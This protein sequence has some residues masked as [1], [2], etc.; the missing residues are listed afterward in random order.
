MSALAPLRREPKLVS[1]AAFGT[2]A[3]RQSPSVLVT[4]RFGLTDPAA[5]L[6]DGQDT[7]DSSDDGEQR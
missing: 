7:Q 1:Q 4:V 3:D 5:A 6:D 2:F